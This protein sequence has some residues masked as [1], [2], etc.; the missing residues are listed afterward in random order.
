MIEM[1]NKQIDETKRMHMRL[2]TNLL[3]HKKNILTGIHER[4]NKSNIKF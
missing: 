3:I 1:Q 4:R 2:K